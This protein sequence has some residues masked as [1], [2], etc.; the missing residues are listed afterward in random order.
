MPLARTTSDAATLVL[1]RAAALSD[2]T[3]APP[4]DPE[5]PGQATLRVADE[6]FSASDRGSAALA[7]LMEETG[8]GPDLGLSDSIGSAS[9]AAA[10][11][12]AAGLAWS[13]AA[14]RL[15]T[16][17]VRTRKSLPDGI[18]F[19]EAATRGDPAASGAHLLG[20]A[21][22]VSG[23]A[24]SFVSGRGPSESVPYGLYR[25]IELLSRD[26]GAGAGTGSASRV[27]AM[28]VLL[29]RLG[30]AHPASA[31]ALDSIRRALEKVRGAGS[32]TLCV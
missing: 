18:E 30:L 12:A 23:A 16:E 20:A 2:S 28:G 15:A 6:N 7:R 22:A 14:T 26:V 24:A 3:P 29:A 9:Q 5:R 13:Y 21:R 27:A 1:F 31:L 10:A 25:S 11:V 19:L 4:H 17:Q 8:E 32:L